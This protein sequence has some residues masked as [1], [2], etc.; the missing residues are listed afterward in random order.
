MRM[1][2]SQPTSKRIND[3]VD[4]IDRLLSYLDP[5]HTRAGEKYEEI[6]RRLIKFFECK[7]RLNA[8]DLTDRTLD[9]VGKKLA[10]EEIQNIPAYAIGVARMV[11][12][13]SWRRPEESSIE[14]ISGEQDLAYT[15]NPE[16]E[17]LSELDA[18][19]RIICLRKCLG[20][21]EE[22][23]R[24]LVLA[25]YSADARKRIEHRR[26]LAESCGRKLNALRVHINRLRESLEH[27][28]TRRLDEHRRKVRI[29]WDQRHKGL[30]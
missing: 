5:D 9:R 25:Y 2:E 3:S 26:K 16:H 15:S 30:C 24:T 19:I 8:E 21:L 18:R 22:S 4:D 12:L 13:E 7:G 17:I 29:A 11:L 6:R 20:E 27:C 28:F 23:D 14:D 10:E 1:T